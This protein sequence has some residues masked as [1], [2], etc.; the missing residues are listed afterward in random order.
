MLN[1]LLLFVL[2]PGADRKVS[3]VYYYKK[4]FIF[5]VKLNGREIAAVGWA[6]LA[7]LLSF[8]HMMLGHELC[9]CFLQ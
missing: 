9:E 4:T 1:P 5:G 7:G 3:K 6:L 2:C 8:W